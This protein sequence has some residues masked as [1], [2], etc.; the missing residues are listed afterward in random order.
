[1]RTS[2]EER[3]GGGQGLGVRKADTNMPHPTQGGA[4]HLSSPREK[5]L[6]R[7]DTSKGNILLGLQ[8]AQKCHRQKGG[9]VRGLSQ[10]LEEGWQESHRSNQ[11]LA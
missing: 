11:A 5:D 4:K 10:G 3:P 6:A 8:T 7:E 2:S 9:A 1:M